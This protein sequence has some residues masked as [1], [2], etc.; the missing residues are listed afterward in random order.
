M[1]NGI[2][3]F[4]QIWSHAFVKKEGRQQFHAIQDLNENSFFF[5]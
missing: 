2:E 4:G 5:D 1:A 3:L